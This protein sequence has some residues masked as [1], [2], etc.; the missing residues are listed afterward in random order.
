MVLSRKF[1][2]SGVDT[3]E[4]GGLCHYHQIFVTAVV[5]PWTVSD[6]CPVDETV[7]G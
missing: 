2:R 3:T 4:D 6:E 1:A 5:K 7:V